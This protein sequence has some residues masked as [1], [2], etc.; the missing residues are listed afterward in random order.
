MPALDSAPILILSNSPSLRTPARELIS[1]S[2]VQDQVAAVF[3]ALSVLGYRS[4]CL[5]IRNLTELLSGLADYTPSLVFNLCE[6][7]DGNSA[8]ESHIAAVLELQDIPFAGSNYL[9]LAL[10]RNKS[11]TKKILHSSGIRTPKGIFCQKIPAVLPAELPFPLICKPACEDASLGIPAQAVARNL[12]ELHRNLKSL[13]N[14]YAHEGVLIE[15]YIAGR[16]FSVALLPEAGGIRAL[17]PTEIDFSAFP[18]G[19]EHIV[20]YDAKWLEGHPLYQHSPS[21]C[22]T[23]LPPLLLQGLQSN[24]LAA[25]AALQGNS[26]ARI[27]FRVDAQERIFALE[28]NPNPDLSPGAGYHKALQAADITYPDFIQ[29][30]IQEATQRKTQA[31]KC[32]I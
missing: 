18:P 29:L 26:Y 20:S 16:E 13:L 30:V 22:P 9:T 2:S 5:S 14:Q 4:I 12:P 7:L 3:S 11:L 15:E 28:Y 27:D 25:G 6:G 21:F 8:F 1:E 31:R 10:A 32:Q 19:Q 23:N 17:P 24:A